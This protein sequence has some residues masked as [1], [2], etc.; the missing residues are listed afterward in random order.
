MQTYHD[1]IRNIHLGAANSWLMISQPYQPHGN[2]NQTTISCHWHSRATRCITANVL[3]INK[4]DAQC[5]KL[6]TELCWQRFA[7][8]VVNLH[9]T[10]PTVPPAFGAFFASD[11][12]WFCRDLRQQK[13]RVPGLS[14]AVIC[15]I[16]RLT[17]S[18][19]HRLVTDRQT[20]RRRQLLWSQCKDGYSETAL[21]ISTAE[22]RTSSVY[23][24]HNVAQ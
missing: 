13:T 23:T 9:L 1:T 11:P 24:V 5:D 6:A 22:S 7:S 3:Q 21:R 2:Q 10:Y 16:L 14:C 15:V 18:V 17:V 4:V 8:N 19:E 12:I 20:D